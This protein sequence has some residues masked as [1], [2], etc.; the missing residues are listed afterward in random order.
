MFQRYAVY[1]TPEGA[2]AECGAAWLG[3]D[4]ARGVYREHPKIGDLDVAG[5][6]QTPRRYGVHGT[7]KPP[8][9]LA[10]GSCSKTLSQ[11][12]EDL[13]H[14]LAP[15]MLEGLQVRTLGR[16]IALT[17]VGDTKALS[18]LA[19]RVVRDLDHF[20]APTREDELSKRRAKGLSLSQEG[21]LAQWGYPHVMEDFRFHITLT[22]RINKNRDQ[23]VEAAHS[24]FAPHL[25][26]PFRVDSL[27]LTGQDADGMFHEIHRFSLNG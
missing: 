20:R 1:Y 14:R 16:F 13:C 24:H 17:P 11:E 8:F 6:T 4:V 15:V 5:L 23:V 12:L 3:W 18:E 2:L 22:E 25:P 9:F 7:I 19:A 27:T 26:V 10:P 21:N